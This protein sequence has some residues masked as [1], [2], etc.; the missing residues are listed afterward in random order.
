MTSSIVSFIA[1]P[2]DGLPGTQ[3]DLLI[4]RNDQS[5]NLCEMKFSVEDYIITKKTWIIFRQKNKFLDI[6]PKQ[7]NTFLQP[8]LQRWVW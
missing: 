6:T 2:K 8:S 3:I 7:R 4:D 5:I 1:R